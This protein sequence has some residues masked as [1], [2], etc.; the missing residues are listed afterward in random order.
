MKVPRFLKVLMPIFVCIVLIRAV[1]GAGALSLNDILVDL[2]DFDFDIDTTWGLISLFSGKHVDA[3]LDFSW[4]YDLTGVSGFF[5]NIGS[6]ISSYFLFL[7]EVVFDLIS[8]VWKVFDTFFSI[9]SSFF[10]LV[11]DIFGFGFAVS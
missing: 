10:N 1:N 7:G 11:Y 9:F 8:V 2:Q 4:N 6:A 5:V 3:V